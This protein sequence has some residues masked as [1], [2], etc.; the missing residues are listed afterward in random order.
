MKHARKLSIFITIISSLMFLYVTAPISTL[1]ERKIG[2]PL[3]GYWVLGG[4]NPGCFE[5]GPFTVIANNKVYTKIKPNEPP[6]LWGDITNLKISN[7]QISYNFLH[8]TNGSERKRIFDDHGNYLV[9]KL[10]SL[11][12]RG[13]NSFKIYKNF[14]N[15]IFFKRCVPTNWYGKLMTTLRIWE[16]R[17]PRSD[18][19]TYVD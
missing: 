3:D 13:E 16:Y 14:N 9:S 2:D 6:F 10:Y 5:N 18:F 12:R 8:K 7:R 11:K 4:D 15:K 17:K 19:L 1:T